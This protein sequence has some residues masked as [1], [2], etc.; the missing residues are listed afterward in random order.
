MLKL[1]SEFQRVYK[2]GRSAHSTS[3][4]LFFIPL[5][6]EIKVGYTASKKVGNAVVR[7]HCKRRLRALTHQHLDLLSDG[8]Y[9][10]VAKAPLDIN[11][12]SDVTKDFR[13]LLKK[14]S[15]TKTTQP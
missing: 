15:S 12:F 2:K 6:G 8:W 1:N 14:I 7:N 13:Y 3:M 9:V 4:A 5:E 11:S 10:W